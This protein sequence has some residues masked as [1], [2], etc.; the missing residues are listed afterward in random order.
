MVALVQPY[1]EE[2]TQTMQTPPLSPWE[3]ST[4]WELRENTAVEDIAHR[5]DD[6]AVSLVEVAVSTQG[7][8]RQLHFLEG[9]A[10]YAAVSLAPAFPTDSLSCH[11][12]R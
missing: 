4:A 7:H 8:Q 5:E 11:P 10:E 2:S 3:L 6:V 9:L 1:E 12:H